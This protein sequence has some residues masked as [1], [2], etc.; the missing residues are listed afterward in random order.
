MFPGRPNS[1]LMPV[2]VIVTGVLW[3]PGWFLNV[4]KALRRQWCPKYCPKL[5]LVCT[6]RWPWYSTAPRQ[7]GIL[8]TNITNITNIAPRIVTNTREYRKYSA[9]FFLKK[10]RQ[11]GWFL[12]I[13]LK[14]FCDIR[15]YLWLFVTIREY[16]RY[17]CAIFA[18]TNTS[19]S[20]RNRE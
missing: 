16:H 11:N 14:Y 3:S 8:S 20:R 19:Y 18:A 10:N 9:H 4:W 5:H 17:S 1:P 2:V 6:L 13:L 7:K 12:Q 15:D